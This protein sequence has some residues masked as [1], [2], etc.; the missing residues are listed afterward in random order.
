MKTKKA[1]PIHEAKTNLSKLI[2]RA[3]K[4]EVIPIGSY[5]KTEVVISLPKEQKTGVKFGTMTDELQ[6]IDDSVLVGLDPDIQ[7]MFFGKDWDK[8]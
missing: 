5:G 8:E 4:G 1:I 2:Q 3:K 6:G 7:E